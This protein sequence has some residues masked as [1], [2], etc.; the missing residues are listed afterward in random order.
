VQRDAFRVVSTVTA[1]AAADGLGFILSLGARAGPFLRCGAVDRGADA[2]H[3][4]TV[5]ELHPD[6][7]EWPDWVQRMRRAPRGGERSGTGP[8]GADLPHHQQ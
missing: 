6:A 7:A 4:A 1:G 5:G 2:I 8:R 3:P